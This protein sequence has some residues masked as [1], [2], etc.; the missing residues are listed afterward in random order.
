MYN[1]YFNSKGYASGNETET[2]TQL[3]EAGKMLLDNLL[4]S[5]YATNIHADTLRLYRTCYLLENGKLTSHNYLMYER[6]VY[7]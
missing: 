5:S 6:A 4:N 7:P 1:S 3:H 2:P